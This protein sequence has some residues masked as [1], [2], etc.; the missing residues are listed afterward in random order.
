MISI[1][2]NKDSSHYIVKQ[3]QALISKKLNT[4]SAIDVKIPPIIELVS[5]S[6][7]SFLK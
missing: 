7:L 4:T 3:S 2:L 5:E 6:V 1:E